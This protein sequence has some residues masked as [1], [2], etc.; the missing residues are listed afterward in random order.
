MR[1]TGLADERA[2]TQIKLS[3]I[4]PYRTKWKKEGLTDTFKP[5]E[6]GYAFELSGAAM[7]RWS[8]Q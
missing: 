5:G 8:R 6:S 1:V 4:E 2:S 7:Q 3:E